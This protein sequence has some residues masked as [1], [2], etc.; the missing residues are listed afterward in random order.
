MN[1]EEWNKFSRVFNLDVEVKV[2]KNVTRSDILQT[3][4]NEGE[5]IFKGK[6]GAW[7]QMNL[8][9]LEGKASKENIKLFDE[10]L[11]ASVIN[12]IKKPKEEKP[13]RLTKLRGKK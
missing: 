4:V 8:S 2:K 5:F 6:N 12:F 10:I 7:T 9:T 3:L 1:S 13:V 11:W